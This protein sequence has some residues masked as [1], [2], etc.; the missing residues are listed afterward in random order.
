MATKPKDHTKT[1]DT[2][3][4]TVSDLKKNLNSVSKNHEK[5]M[6]ARDKETS[7]DDHKA[8]LDHF[9]SQYKMAKM[10]KQEDKAAEYAKSYHDYASKLDK[11]YHAKLKEDKINEIGDPEEMYNKAAATQKAKLKAMKAMDKT[12]KYELMR[13]YESTN[14]NVV[15]GYYDRD[16]FSASKRA[17]KRAEL[18]HELGHEDRAMARSRYRTPEKK[19]PHAVH[20]NGKKWKTFDT[21]RH[22]Q[23]VANK[24]KGAT[25]HK[26][27]YEIEEESNQ[28]V[29]STYKKIAVQHL[30]DMMAKNASNSS[31]IYAK[32]MHQRALEASKMSN[33]TDA[34]NHYRGVKEEAEQVDEAVTVDKK[35]YSWG[36]MVTVHHGS[37]N[38]YPLHP[39]HQ[40]AIKKLKDGEHTTFKDETNRKVTA[41]R[42]GDN[43]HLSGSGSNKKT[44]VAYSHFTE[45][46]KQVDELNRK[47]LAS[48]VSKAAGSYGRDKQLIGRTSPDGTVKSADPDLKRAV[49]N[50]LT[51]I[52]R[53]AERLAKEESSP[54]IKAPTN[55]FG[56]KEDAFSHAKEHGGKVFKKTFIHPTSGQKNVSYVVRKESVAEST[57]QSLQKKIQAK[58]DALGLAREKRRALGQHQQGQ[59]EIKLQA[60]I[61]NLSIQLTQMKKQV[62]MK[63]ARKFGYDAINARLKKQTGRS[64]EDRIKH[65]EAISARLKKQQD[66][67]EAQQKD[68]QKNEEL[69]YEGEQGLW[70][71][72]HAKRAR[73]KAGSGERMRKPGSKGAPTKQDFKDAQENFI[74]GRN[75]QDKGDMARHGMKGK[76]ITQLKKI[77]SSESASPRKKQ[78]AHWYINMHKK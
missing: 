58:R 59:R 9:A 49:K 16:P 70:A 65:Y 43:V 72:I 76:S 48:Y 7:P 74:D 32:K 62:E 18:E 68:R 51:G 63:E 71:N 6:S 37:E 38:S 12:R 57:E 1:I 75:P 8:A 46:V 73:I 67:Y 55:E 26:E 41:H 40:E 11:H 78:L 20:I 50:R 42:E 29:A 54:M 10:N 33:H 4:K 22:A 45:E 27:E 52:N 36:K 69:F 34:L 5:M 31:K 64:I 28:E 21:Q 25:V 23:N 14:D 47:T 60:E 19:E 15:E 66:E 30:K 24:I 44:T 61:D 53:A 77:R 3:K 35:N 13:K 56:K 2:I 17:F 39:E